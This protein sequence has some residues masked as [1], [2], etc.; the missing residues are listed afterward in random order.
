[1]RNADISTSNKGILHHTLIEKGLRTRNTNASL[2]TD[3]FLRFSFRK[4]GLGINV[5]ASMTDNIPATP[6]VSFKA[7]T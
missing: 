3:N 2:I 7:D 1:M 5:T 6:D 4:S